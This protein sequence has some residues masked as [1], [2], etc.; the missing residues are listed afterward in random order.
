MIVRIYRGLPGSGKTTEAKKNSGFHIEEDMLHIKNGIYTFRSDKVKD[1]HDWC[2]NQFM[3][4]LANNMDVSI[5][6]TFT[7]RWEFERYI[8]LAERCEASVIVYRMTG[9]YGSV[10]GVPD[11]VFAKMEERFEDFKGE[12]F[13]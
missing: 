1:A 11:D 3:A 12:I 9:E 13:I 10:H 4:A 5:S 2:H 8:Y 6:N 7:R